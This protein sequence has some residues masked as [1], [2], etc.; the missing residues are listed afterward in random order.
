MADDGEL[1]RRR[2][3]L[4]GLGMAGAAGLL[5]SARAADLPDDRAADEADGTQERLPFFGAHQSGVVTPQP[6]A[7]LYA[8][9]DVLAAD[10]D[11]LDRLFRLL[12]G[13]I[14]FLAQGGPA[15]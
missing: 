4:M 7:A 11:D 15:A 9:F 10:R 5:G 1:K 3:F 13:R 12:T 6:A 2:G 8:A 14:A